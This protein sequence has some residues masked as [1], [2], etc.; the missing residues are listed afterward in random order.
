MAPIFTT[1]D[2]TDVLPLSRLFIP[3]AVHAEIHLFIVICL[4]PPIVERVSARAYTCELTDLPP[5]L[6]A[7]DRLFSM[8]V[9]FTLAKRTVHGT[10]FQ[11]LPH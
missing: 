11:P 9:Q 8:K 4:Q 7:I 3:P 10:V 5:P 2:S 6:S 1:Y